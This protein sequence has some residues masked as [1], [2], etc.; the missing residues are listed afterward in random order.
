[1]G[2]RVGTVTHYFPH[3][4]A[5]AV[6][7]EQGEIRVGDLLQFHGHTTDFQQRVQR[8]ELEHEAILVARVGQIVG[9]QVDERVREHDQ[10]LKLPSE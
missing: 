7:V 9:V 1:M 8:I 10:V 3:V 2:T 6:R 5:A 4:N